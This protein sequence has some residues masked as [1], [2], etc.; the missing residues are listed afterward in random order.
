MTWFGHVFLFSCPCFY[1][2][3]HGGFID[4]TENNKH[5][6]LAQHEMVSSALRKSTAL[7]LFPQKEFPSGTSFWPA[8]CRFIMYH[9]WN[10]QQPALG[11][12]DIIFARRKLSDVCIPVMLG[13]AG[14]QWWSKP[15]II[16]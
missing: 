4:L 9:V 12:K 16:H 13:E 10:Y 14:P 3:Q 5:K 2:C 7:S 15:R 1:L 6:I 8:V 11:R